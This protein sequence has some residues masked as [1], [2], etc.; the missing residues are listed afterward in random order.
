MIAVVDQ[1]RKV[2]NCFEDVADN[3][4]VAPLV[5]VIFPASQDAEEGGSAGL[6][7]VLSANQIGRL[8]AR[9]PL[10]LG[11]CL[12]IIQSMLLFQDFV[13]RVTVIS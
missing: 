6:P 2:I 10:R 8:F 12:H 13:R 3:K 9:R 4:S 7:I 5:L 11:D 1:R